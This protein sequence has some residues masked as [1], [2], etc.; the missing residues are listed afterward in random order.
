MARMVY[1]EYRR[2]GRGKVD[3]CIGEGGG[4]GRRKGKRDGKDS[5]C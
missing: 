3:V 5:I 1:V 4:G 2:M